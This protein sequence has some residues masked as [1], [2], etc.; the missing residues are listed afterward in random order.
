MYKSIDNCRAI[1]SKYTGRYG[2][3]SKCEA[4]ELQKAYE[5][6][7]E[8][9]NQCCHNFNEFICFSSKVMQCKYCMLEMEKYK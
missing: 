9:Q 6:I 4:E 2:N 5:D 3:L 8:L 1:I 7:K